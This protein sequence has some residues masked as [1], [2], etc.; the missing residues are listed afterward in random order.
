MIVAR[1]LSS[2]RPTSSDNCWHANAL[3]SASNIVGNRGGFM[4]RKVSASGRSR[5]SPAAVRYQSVRSIRSPSSRSRTDRACRFPSIV[6]GGGVAVTI[7]L[8]AADE[9]VCRTASS[10]GRPSMTI[11][12]RYVVPSHRSIRLRG[13]RRSAHTVRSRR[14]GGIGCSTNVCAASRWSMKGINAASSAAGDAATRPLGPRRPA[15]LLSQE[16]LQGDRIVVLRVV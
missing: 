11:T 12:R 1:R 10:V 4:P 3:T 14:N 6:R 9:P 2:S 15:R 7:S 5:A 13:R 16:L 8:G